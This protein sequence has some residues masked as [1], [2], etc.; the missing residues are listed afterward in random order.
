MVILEWIGGRSGLVKKV[1][2]DFQEEVTI[3]LK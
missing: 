1:K 3:E 2:K